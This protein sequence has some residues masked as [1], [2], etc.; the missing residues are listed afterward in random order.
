MFL[1][2]CFGATV[3]EGYGLSESTSGIVISDPSDYTTGARAQMCVPVR[4]CVCARA[5]VCVC[6]LE[7]WVARDFEGCKRGGALLGASPCACCAAGC[8]MSCHLTAIIG[9]WH[10]PRRPR[11]RAHALN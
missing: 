3:M 9:G 10:L 8:Q 4:M 5:C 2:I 1:R 6:V 11:G 7:W